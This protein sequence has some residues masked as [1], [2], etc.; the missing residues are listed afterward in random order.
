[1]VSFYLSPQVLVVGNLDLGLTSVDVNSVSVVSAVLKLTQPGMA[2][3]APVT[4]P[5][6]TT[7]LMPRLV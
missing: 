4:P 5:T 2:T 3:S 7:G 1:M 6:F